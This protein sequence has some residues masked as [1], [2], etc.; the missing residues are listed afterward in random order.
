MVTKPH[1]HRK[2]ITTTTPKG[3]I[4]IK[5]SKQGTLHKALGVPLKKKIPAPM[6]QPKPSD[7]PVMA[8][9]K[10]FARNV[11]TFNH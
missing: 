4:H 2:H 10:L 9:K 1:Q 3:T 11:R 8:K 6:L 5:Q 7:S